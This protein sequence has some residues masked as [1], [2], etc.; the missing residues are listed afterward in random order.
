MR[1]GPAAIAAGPNLFGGAVCGPSGP[2][3]SGGLGHQHGLA[4]LGREAAPDAVGLPRGKRPAQAAL[5]DRAAGTDGL[6]AHLAAHARGASLV[7]RVIELAGVGAAARRARLP[8]PVAFT[9][10]GE[11]S[12]VGH[13]FADPLG[14]AGGTGLSSVV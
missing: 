5:H 4:L 9:Q 14:L 2:A 7:L 6:G 12:L 10:S 8:V 11:T 13:R 1:N 3:V